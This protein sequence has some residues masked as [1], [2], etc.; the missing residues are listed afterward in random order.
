MLE[1]IKL[2]DKEIAEVEKNTNRGIRGV[3]RLLIDLSK[4]RGEERQRYVNLSTS[5]EL[6]IRELKEKKE[7]ELMEKAQ[8]RIT[9]AELT[10]YAESQLTDDYRE[11]KEQFGVKEWI[12]PIINSYYEWVNGHKF[13]KKDLTKVEQFFNN[14]DDE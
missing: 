14:N 3:N 8:K 7:A 6:N 11:L 2:I 4:K 9:D 1:I 10:R 12:E 5:Y 13:D